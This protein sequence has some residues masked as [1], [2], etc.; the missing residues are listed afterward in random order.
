MRF[1]SFCTHILAVG[2]IF[3][4][5]NHR[6]CEFNSH[7]GWFRLVKMVP[8]TS[9]DQSLTV[10]SKLFEIQ[11]LWWPKKSSYRC[12][13]ERCSS[14]ECLYCSMV[15]TITR[16]T[17]AATRRWTS[18]Q[19]RRPG[20]CWSPQKCVT[21]GLYIVYKLLFLHTVTLVTFL[22]QLFFK[23]KKS[24]YCHH[25]GVVCVGGCVVVVV[26]TNFNLGYNLSVEANIKLHLLVHHHKNHNLTKNHNSARLFDKIIPLYRFAKMDCV[27]I[28]GVSIVCEKL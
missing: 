20:C 15:R 19:G 13:Y 18:G 12:K 17:V 3:T 9:S 14:C 7:F 21:H 28:T 2:A 25:S 26:V 4:S 8:T 1:L 22:A 27:L 23:E 6:K 16:R 5:Q 11:L 24:R 10:F